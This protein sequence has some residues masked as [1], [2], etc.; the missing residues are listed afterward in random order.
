ML[1][2]IYI[3]EHSK[4]ITDY[5]PE[6]F[7]TITVLESKPYNQHVEYYTGISSIT[8]HMIKSTIS[9]KYIALKRIWNLF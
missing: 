7:R 2:Y 9:I 6:I 5:K 1:K 8:K 4:I 3:D